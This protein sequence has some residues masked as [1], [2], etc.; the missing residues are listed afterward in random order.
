MECRKRIK[1]PEAYILLPDPICDQSASANTDQ[2]SP[3]FVTLLFGLFAQQPKVA[4]TKFIPVTWLNLR[5]D[6]QKLSCVVAA[7]VPFVDGRAKELRR[8]LATARAGADKKDCV[9]ETLPCV[10]KWD[11]N[12]LS[13]LQFIFLIPW[14]DPP[15]ELF[16]EAGS[17]SLSARM[18]NKSRLNGGQITLGSCSSYRWEYYFQLKRFIRRNVH[19]VHFCDWFAQSSAELAIYLFT[20]MGRGN[21]K[22]CRALFENWLKVLVRSNVHVKVGIGPMK[23]P[24]EKQTHSKQEPGCRS[25]RGLSYRLSM[26]DQ[27]KNI[28]RKK[29]ATNFVQIPQEH[30]HP[31]IDGARQIRGTTLG[32]V[33]FTSELPQTIAKMASDGLGMKVVY[34]QKHPIPC[35]PY[36]YI[37]NMNELLNLSDIILLSDDMMHRARRSHYCTQLV[38]LRTRKPALWLTQ[39]HFKQCRP[40]AVLIC[41]T[42]IQCLDF[43]QLSIAL[44]TGLLSGA[45]IAMPTVWSTPL[46]DLQQ[47]C[48]LPNALV[49]PPVSSSACTPPDTRRLFARTIVQY[50]I[51]L[52][53][54]PVAVNRI[55]SST[56]RTWTRSKVLVNFTSV[57]VPD[58]FKGNCSQNTTTQSDPLGDRKFKTSKA[59]AYIL[60][61]VQ[62]WITRKIHT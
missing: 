7:L 25:Y 49:L 1:P 59:L 2:I 30:N 51:E 16:H 31:T 6:P 41:V 23:N 13:N 12:K 22:E 29:S 15:N 58:N 43:L 61:R 28:G 37:E 36:R 18:L 4:G 9:I 44:R 60:F 21:F 19:I 10:K 48:H 50:L 53:S 39:K 27:Q 45:G 17:I 54:K 47:L 38:H 52:L 55:T 33:G 34:H 32:L 62:Q 5:L 14:P 57:P 8:S 26:A 46:S 42:K 11:C 56:T 40:H 3:C 24:P 35:V 20:S